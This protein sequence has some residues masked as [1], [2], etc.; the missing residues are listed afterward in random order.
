MGISASRERQLRDYLFERPTTLAQDLRFYCREFPLSH[1]AWKSDISQLKWD[2]YSHSAKH[3]D[4]LGTRGKKLVLCELKYRAGNGDAAPL[5]LVQYLLWLKQDPV[6]R[7]RISETMGHTFS[8]EEDVELFIVVIGYVSKHT[9]ETARLLSRLHSSD[10]TIFQAMPKNHDAKVWS[11]WAFS[12]V[13]KFE[14]RSSLE[15]IAT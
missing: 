14:G 10:T 1:E 13:A 15:S 11:S 8:F 5:Q 9:C 4:L 12:E 3:I 7:T 2:K 6:A